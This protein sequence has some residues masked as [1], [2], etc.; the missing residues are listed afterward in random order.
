[1]NGHTDIAV[2]LMWGDKE[3]MDN[4]S[5]SNLTLETRTYDGSTIVNPHTP[6]PSPLAP[7]SLSLTPQPET[8]N[9]KPE[10]RNPNAKP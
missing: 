6:H 5:D 7:L 8:R 2:K 9:P 10:T 1:M 4:L 3:S